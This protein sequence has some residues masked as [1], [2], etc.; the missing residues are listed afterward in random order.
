MIRGIAA[1]GSVVVGLTRSA[2]KLLLEGKPVL[3]PGF[4]NLGPDVVIVFAEDDKALRAKL[5]EKASIGPQ[6]VE[7]DRRKS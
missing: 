6:T 4:D 2:L 1:N 7:H 5:K 3:S